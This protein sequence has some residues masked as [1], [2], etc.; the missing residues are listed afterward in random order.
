MKSKISTIILFLL[1]YIQVLGNQ[2]Y[3]IISSTRN[4][5]T[6]EYKPT[7]DTSYISINNEK[8]IRIMLSRGMLPDNYLPG[9]PEIQFE[10]INVGVPSETGNTIQV[11]STEFKDINSKIAP[12]PKIDV[13]GGIPSEVYELN[14]NYKYVPE[15]DLVNFGDYGLARNLQ[16]QSINIYP[17][18]NEQNKIRLYTKI[19]FKINFSSSKINTTEDK[20]EFTKDAVVNYNIAKTWKFETQKLKKQ[21][22]FN[23]VLS[24]GKWYR[25]EAP[26]EGIYIINR[27]TLQSIGIDPNTV[28]PRTIKIYNNGGKVLSENISTPRPQDLV[29]NAIF[30]SGEEDGKFDNSDYIL[31]YGRGI[32][33]W[34]YDPASNKVVRY[35]HPY[36]KQ[37]YYFITSGGSPGERMQMEENLNTTPDVVQTTT[38]A[39]FGWEE[40]KAKLIPSGRLYLGDAITDADRVKTYINNL[41]GIISGSQISYRFE[42]VNSSELGVPFTIEENNNNI[43]ST[44]LSGLGIGFRD[45]A[46]SN[47]GIKYTVNASYTGI[48]PSDRSVLRFDYEPT[49]S[50]SACYLNYIE[51][52]YN[53]NLVP[54]DNTL[55]F[56]SP[57]DAGVIEYHL[58]NFPSSDIKVFDISDFSNVKY[59]NSPN[60]SAGD[61]I[62][63]KNESSGKTSKFIAIAN[64]AYKTPVNFSSVEN[65]NLHGI[66]DGAKF[67]IITATD[68]KEQ[69]DRY[70][71]FKET[72]S[73]TKMS[74]IVVTCDQI[75]NEFSG[76]LQDVSSIRD[77]IKYAYDNWPV[78]PEYVLLFGDGTYDYKNVEG[79]SLNFVIPWESVE[80]LGINSYCS[81]DFY[82]YVKGNDSIVD[83]AIGRL[84]VNS[85]SDATN[86][87][88]KIIRYETRS[89]YGLWRDLITLVADDQQTSERYD[90]APHNQQSEDLSNNYIPPSYI[91]NKIYE[92]NY[93]LVQTSI[94]RRRPE[95]NKAI[96]KAINDGTLII[97]WTGHGNPDVWAH[98]YV[99]EKNVT[100][101]QLINDN[102]CFLTAATCD[103]GRYDTPGNQSSTEIMILKPDGGTIGT[104]SSARTVYSEPNA[105]LNNVFYSNLLS[106]DSLNH[107]LPI[108]KAYFLTKIVRHSTNDLKFH[109][110]GDPTLRLIA[111]DFPAKIDSIN[112][113]NI[114][115]KIQIKALSNVKIDG[116]VKTP[117]GNTDN[118]F[119]GEAI[120]T[121]YDSQKLIYLPDAGINMTVQGGVI[122]KGRSS[123]ANGTYSTSFIVPKD[124]SYENKTG[125]IVGYIYNSE[126][127][128]LCYSDSVIVGGTDNTAVNDGKGPEIDISFDNASSEDS[129][130]VNPDC[131][132][133]VKLKDQT[134]LNT[135][136]SGIGHTL[137]GILNGNENSPIDFTNYFVGDLNADG[138]SGYIQYNFYGLDEGDYTIKVNAW[139][140]F[141]NYS[142]AEKDFTVVSGNDLVVR[143]IVNYPNPFKS[144]T[145]FTFQHN[146]SQPINI[147][148]KVYTVAGR[149]IK[150]LEDY[151]ISDKFVRINWDGRDADGN[152]LANGVY[153]Y[154]LI[155][156]SVDGNYNK[157]AL[158]KL[159]VVR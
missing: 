23:S 82:V 25:F 73:R 134:G 62:F 47:Q 128:A 34:E 118:N 8:Y 89:E 115:S 114:S 46:E 2:N 91:Q 98:E 16:I 49:R 40:D 51:I 112:G 59:V 120:I 123:V 63:R 121:A 136:G 159:A 94:G 71:N 155:V 129:Y 103:F 36:S 83:L 64:S 113:S 158:G 9:S 27:S 57:N 84:N 32:N 30:V 90:S 17:I 75:F 58:S 106:R 125:K 45:N 39:Y 7:Y 3:K 135:T 151:D 41:S 65:S 88:D 132:L 138:R 105:E 52:Y 133:I 15:T 12:I 154:K 55:M 74:T 77:F 143:D 20:D 38:A 97:N 4:S 50:P 28:D 54:A 48:L 61:C 44:S 157:E 111:P 152:L 100:I 31:F 78:Q 76:G 141:N 42:I 87:V 79:N 148:I 153:L 21:A 93:P 119:D 26:D 109:L 10:K 107:L 95:V 18:Q 92:L 19:V 108:G 81:D 102:Y 131:K 146:L 14:E 5:L 68:F 127:D 137:S 110:F 29:E 6:I 142:S 56:Y 35:Y 70:K 60:I 37:N 80:S 117:V 145:T 144:N 24:T 67:I 53:K 130:L 33:F 13:K 150:V 124:I 101:P 116:T 66:T 1:I 22:V 139:D 126:N 99:F 85:V 86:V 96:I 43:Y 140:V 156:K 149:L 72:S 147:R 122:Y 104:F 11:L 69:A